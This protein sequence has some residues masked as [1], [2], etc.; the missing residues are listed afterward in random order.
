VAAKDVIRPE[1]A[2]ELSELVSGKCPVRT[3]DKQITLFKSVG[4]A[5]QDVA[6]AVKVYQNALARGLGEKIDGFPITLEKSA[7]KTYH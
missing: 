6:L 3:D 4:T 5:V 2:F 1:Q 7:E